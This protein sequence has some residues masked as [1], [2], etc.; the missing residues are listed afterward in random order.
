M[1]DSGTICLSLLNEDSGWRPAITVK[2]LLIGIQ[3][4]LDNPNPDSPAQ[5]EAIEVFLR[6]KAEYKR[7]IKEQAQRNVPD[8]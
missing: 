7:R 8:T 1:F 5:R 2:Q 3:D 6:N 4:L